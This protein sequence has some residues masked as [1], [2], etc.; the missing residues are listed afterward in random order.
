MKDTSRFA[1][2]F[3]IRSYNIR[4]F[5]GGGDGVFCLGIQV[6]EN[7]GLI[8]WFWGFHQ[9]LRE[10]SKNPEAAATTPIMEA[11]NQLS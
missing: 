1:L 6:P 7:S 5:E 10:N 9:G 2:K 3:S 11:D 8:L 4:N